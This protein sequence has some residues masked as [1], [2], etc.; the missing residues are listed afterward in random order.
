MGVS[1]VEILQLEIG[2]DLTAPVLTRSVSLGIRASDL[3]LS[4]AHHWRGACIVSLYKGKGDTCAC[5]NSRGISLLSVVGKLFGRVL[6]KRVR[7]GTKCAI[8]G[9]QCMFRQ[10]IAV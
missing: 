8:G 9:L 2:V 10:G 5:S 6:I 7:A 1:L 4:H 3:R